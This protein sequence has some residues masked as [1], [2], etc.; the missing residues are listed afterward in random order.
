ML[1]FRMVG[2][3]ALVACLTI[4][5]CADA[6]VTRRP[7]TAGDLWLVKRVGSLA[8]SPDGRMAA[9][10]VTVYDI[11]KNEGQGDIWLVATDGRV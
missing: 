6:S 9:V 10:V 11:E 4:A 1:R 7:I 8:V 3:V 5:L 2:A